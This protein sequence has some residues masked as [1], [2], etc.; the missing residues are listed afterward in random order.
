[1]NNEQLNELIKIQQGINRQQELL[2]TMLQD[3]IEYLENKIKEE[4]DQTLSFIDKLQSTVI[5]RK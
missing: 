4:R 1:M 3:R 2:I 5:G